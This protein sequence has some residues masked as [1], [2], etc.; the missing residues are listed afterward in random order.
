MFAEDSVLVQ[1]NQSLSAARQ[2][3]QGTP[4]QN[5]DIATSKTSS[6]SSM[7]DPTIPPQVVV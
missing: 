3:K 7:Q 2:V 6:R 5:Q 1:R 4:Y